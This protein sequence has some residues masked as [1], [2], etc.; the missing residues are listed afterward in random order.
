MTRPS[1]RIPV[2]NFIAYTKIEIIPM[3]K[4]LKL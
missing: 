3:P 1:N 4:T 2:G